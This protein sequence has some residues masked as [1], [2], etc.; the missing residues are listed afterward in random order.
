MNMKYD[1]LALTELWRKQ[2]KFQKRNKVE[3]RQDLGAS[4]FTEGN[5]QVVDLMCEQIECADILVANK[6][7]LTPPEQLGL[8]PPEQPAPRRSCFGWR[9]TP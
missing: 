3:E 8:G 7:D 9:R 4:E 1:I 5:R 6:T 2:A